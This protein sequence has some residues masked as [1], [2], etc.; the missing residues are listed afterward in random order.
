MQGIIAKLDADFF[1]ARWRRATERQREL[2]EVISIL[3]TA[4]TEFTVRHIVAESKEA[5]ERPFGASQV[6]QMLDSLTKVGLIFKHR[7]GR[8][9]FAVPLLHE[10]INRQTTGVN[11][12]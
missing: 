1:N 6:N 12:S 9:S 5:L 10:F 8:Y 4:G 11:L 7:H 2:L 3:P